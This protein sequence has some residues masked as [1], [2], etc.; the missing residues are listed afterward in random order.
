VWIPPSTSNPYKPE[1]DY[2]G[3][4]T[5]IKTYADAAT[6]DQP[7]AVVNTRSYDITGNMVKSTTSWCEETSLEFTTSTQYAYP[8]KQ[9]RSSTTDQF[10]QVVTK[11]TYDFN[12][13]L[14]I[15]TNDANDRQSISS[16]D[17]NTLRLASSVSPT[18]AHT[19]YDYNNATMTLTATSYASSGE[20]G[21]IAD[22]SVQLLNGKGQVRQEQAL[23]AN[24]IWDFVDTTYDNMSRQS[25][26][27][28][29]YRTGDTKQW[30]TITYDGLDR[31]LTMATP[32]GS[33]TSFFYNELARPSGAS[34]NPGDT[35]R[36]QDPWGRERWRRTDANGWPVEIMEPDPNGN[37]SVS[38][39]GLLTTYS[40]NTLGDLTQ[41]I[42]GDQTRSFKYDSLGRLLA[43]KLAEANASLNDAGTY[44]GAGTW[45]D[46]FTYDVRSNL[47]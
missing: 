12:T 33:T 29:P 37:G 39:G 32:D 6:L 46:V 13:G 8:E 15:T 16:Y 41:I 30:S 43:Q 35:T 28:Q 38:T 21:L 3:N 19:D 7:T 1:T 2:R 9:T 24:G 10:A 22:Q 31:I 18:G 36:I 47:T 34:S 5:Q 45:S 44:V 42:Q 25:Q 27:T 23:G 4:V 14:N 40:Y 11:A 26:Q 17:P 20:G